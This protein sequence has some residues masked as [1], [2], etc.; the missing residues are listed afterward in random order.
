VLL[1]HSG[2]G[3]FRPLRNGWIGVDLFFV[4]SG[5]L[6]T[7]ILVDA[8]GSAHALR[9]F[10]VRRVLRIWPLY[11]ALLLGMFLL[12]RAAVTFAASPPDTPW[13][14]YLLFIQN[15]SVPWKGPYALGVTWSLAIE[16]Q[17][18]ILWPWVVL[19]LPARRSFQIACALFVVSLLMRALLCWSGANGELLYRFTACRLD[20]LAVGAMMAIWMRSPGYSARRLSQVS[21]LAVAT[22]PVTLLILELAVDRMEAQ[23]NPVV[24]V[25]CHSALS[26]GFAGLLGMSLGGGR[27]LWARLMR[28]RWLRWLGTVS[29]GAYLLHL[30]LLDA[31]HVYLYPTIAAFKVAGR[32]PP[33]LAFA[34]AY[35][36]VLG[37]VALSWYGFER[38]ILRLKS[39]FS[40]H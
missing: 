23:L 37:A 13:W 5:F 14:K 36:F 12:G 38:P 2:S 4:L 17:F 39:R 40:S 22:L 31:F 32:K 35:A 29:Y 3:L 21:R 8:R 30:P 16:E 9:N 10:Y 28:M 7:G 6:I 19:F 24:R 15:F 27:H 18:Y 34:A 33:G 11:Y 20:G 25:F 26:F 1:E